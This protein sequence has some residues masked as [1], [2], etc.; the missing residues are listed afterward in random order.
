MT[1]A[2][3]LICISCRFFVQIRFFNPS[4]TSMRINKPTWLRFRYKPIIC[5]QIYAFLNQTMISVTINNFSIFDENFGCVSTNEIINLD[6][7]RFFS[8][9]FVCWVS[10]VRVNVTLMARYVLHLHYFEKF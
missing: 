3:F 9:S 8:S 4:L 5:S 1:F 2:K 10:F 7:L 6:R